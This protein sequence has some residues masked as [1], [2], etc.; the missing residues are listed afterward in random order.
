MKVKGHDTDKIERS[1][2]FEELNLQELSRKE[3]EQT[4]AGNIWAGII[5][6]WVVSEVVQGV[7]QAHKNGCI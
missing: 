5:V 4:I 6:G 2:K 7:Y 3:L 1:M